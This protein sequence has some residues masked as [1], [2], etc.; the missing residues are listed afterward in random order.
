MGYLKDPKNKVSVSCEDCVKDAK[1]GIYRLK[2]HL[3]GAFRNITDCPK[4]PEHVKEEITQF[5][6]KKK[7]L[8]DPIS[9]LPNLDDLDMNPEE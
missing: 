6:S 2:Q 1:G 5:M 7:P 8:K 9:V 3:V 4:E